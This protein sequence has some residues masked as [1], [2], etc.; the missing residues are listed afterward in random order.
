MM[1]LELTTAGA[2]GGSCTAGRLTM[3]M[4]KKKFVN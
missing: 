4:R 2:E 1:L 3:Q